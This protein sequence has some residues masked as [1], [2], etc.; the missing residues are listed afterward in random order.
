MVGNTVSHFKR[1]RGGGLQMEGGG[2]V[3]PSISSSI[4][5]GVVV[6]CGVKWEMVVNNACLSRVQAMGN[7]APPPHVSS[8]GGWCVSNGRW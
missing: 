3:S 8:E 7:K 6:D 1:G 4:E 2:Q 5:R